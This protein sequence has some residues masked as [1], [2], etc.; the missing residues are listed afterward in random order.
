[1]K[2][3]LFLS[4]FQARFSTEI[5]E[6]YM[7]SEVI[8]IDRVKYCIEQ[9][10]YDFEFNKS[11]KEY[12]PLLLCAIARIT[13]EEQIELMIGTPAEHTL[14][15]RDEFKSKL[16][17]QTFNFKYNGEN[18]KVT[19]VKV[20]VIGE[21]L[22]TYFTIEKSLRKSIKNLGILDIG[23]RTSNILTFVNG[24]QEHIHSINRGIVDVKKELK[25]EEKKKRQGL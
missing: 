3:K 7:N 15:L 10:K 11:K 21:G 8:E 12:I 19:F 23:G 18:R 13:K 5:Q 1:M 22:A 24:K 2:G 4:S 17:G 6:D 25:T 14:G 20:G 16:E 9:G